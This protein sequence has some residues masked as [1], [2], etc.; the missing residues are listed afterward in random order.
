VG[1]RQYLADFPHMLWIDATPV[2][3]FEQ[4]SQTFVLKTLDHRRRS[5][6]LE[7]V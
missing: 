6:L 5:R 2:I 3:V 7:Q 1:Q 4:P